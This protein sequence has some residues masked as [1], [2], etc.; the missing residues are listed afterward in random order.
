MIKKAYILHDNPE[1]FF[2][3]GEKS[4]VLFSRVA[5]KIIF[6]VAGSRGVVILRYE[7]G[8][9]SNGMFQAR[10]DAIWDRL[11]SHIGIEF[12][13]EGNRRAII[14]LEEEP[15]DYNAFSITGDFM[16]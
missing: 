6:E 10:R 1:D 14:A 3:F 2:K 13:E 11:R 8:I 9:L 12:L 7:G 5:A 4:V 16:K 15:D